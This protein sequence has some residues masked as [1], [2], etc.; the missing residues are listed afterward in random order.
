MSQV[1]L[2]QTHKSRCHK[3]Y[4]YQTHK[5]RCQVLLY[6]T[7]KSRCHKSGLLAI[8][9]EIDLDTN[10]GTVPILTQNVLAQHNNYLGL[11]LKEKRK[12][13]RDAVKIRM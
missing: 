13:F 12:S 2:Y 9:D 11:M 6:Q 4:L 8:F 1:L 10:I 5:S 3:F 7:H